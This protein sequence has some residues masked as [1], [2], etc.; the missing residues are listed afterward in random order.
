M[1]RTYQDI[2]R[3]N[4]F[5]VMRHLIATAP[6]VRRDIAAATGLSVATASDI[7]NEL[8]EL[9]LLTEIGQQASGGGRPRNLLAPAVEGPRLIGVD[10]A[11]TYVHVEVFDPSLQVLARAEYELH[12]HANPPE[13]VVDR[14]VRGVDEAIARAQVERGRVL[15]V[16]V[17]IPGQVR[18]DGTTSVFAPNWNWNDVPLRD[19]LTERIP[20]LPILLDNPLRASTVAE[21]WFGAARG[22]DNVAVLTLGTGVGAGLTVQGS[23]YRGATNTAGEWGHTNLVI[24]GRECR[25]GCVGCVETYVGAPGIMQHL[26]E[27]HPDSPLLHPDDQMATIHA[28]ATAH[29][30]KDP[31]AQQV[32]ATTGRYLGIAIANLINLCN[33]QIIV[34]TGWVA[35]SLGSAVLP[36]VRATAARYA[37]AEPWEGTEISLCPIDRN[38]VSLGAATLVLEGFLS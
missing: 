28:L 6:V 37:L 22:R 20:D 36:H 12:P 18:A 30:A 14:I 29:A 31:A 15:G 2:R 24:D 23:L 11:E 27:I 8:H 9:G 13:Y 38:P 32:I 3:T 21:L 34:L 26:A 25:R 17:S 33:P 19:L 7:V 16:G 5:A 1:K 10:I 4:R 35:D